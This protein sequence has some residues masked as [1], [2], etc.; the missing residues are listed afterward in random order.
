MNKRSESNLSV[1]ESVNSLSSSRERTRKAKEAGKRASSAS[2][3]S[4]LNETPQKTPTIGNV[5]VTVTNNIQYDPN[6]PFSF[7][8][9]VD[10]PFHKKVRKCMGPVIA[11]IVLL[12]LAACLGAAIY[13]ATALK[14]RYS[15][16]SISQS[17]SS[18]QTTD[19][20]K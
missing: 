20:S 12:I 7:I 2:I 5:A 13:F 1:D 9:P 8:Q 4:K 3:D 10:L 14:G 19:I 17:Q 6:D 16:L 18:S 11:V 15:Q